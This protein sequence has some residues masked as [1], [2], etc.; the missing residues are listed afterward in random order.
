MQN[1]QTDELSQV[2]VLLPFLSDCMKID[3][4]SIL[5][6][7]L[8]AISYLT[9]GDNNQLNDVMKFISL[10]AVISQAKK[11]A[12]NEVRLPSIRIIGNFLSGTHEHT[13]VNSYL[14]SLSK[15]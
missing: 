10:Q 13:A 5:E 12:K 1:K 6:N 11:D 14:N 15:T 2:C 8:W 9:D 3:D 7:V 4:L